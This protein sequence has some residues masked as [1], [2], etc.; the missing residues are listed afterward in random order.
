M[1]KKSPAGSQL[2]CPCES[3]A[4]YS[5]CCSR[6]VADFDGTPAPD[7]ERLMRSRYSAFVLEQR[8]YLLATW[9]ASTRP[10]QLDFEPQCRWMGLQVK[11]YRPVDDSHAEV[12]FVARY[13]LQGRAVRLHERSR[14]V[15]EQGRWF[16]LDGDQF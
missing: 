8:D 15:K 2:R 13:K 16:Y 3:G 14:F 6:F 1:A 4:T 7:A 10:S 9:H 5:A 12:E 11:A